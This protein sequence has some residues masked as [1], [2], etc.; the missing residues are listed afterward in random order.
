MVTGDDSWG[1]R[2]GADNTAD[3]HCHRGTAITGTADRRGGG[4]SGGGRGGGDSGGFL[5]VTGGDGFDDGTSRYGANLSGG[6][7]GGARGSGDRFL[8]AQLAVPG[9]MEGGGFSRPDIRTAAL[10]GADAV[11]GRGQADY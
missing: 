9:G 4:G 11:D 7:G 8:R 3:G 10:P 6:V 2:G 1:A 5:G